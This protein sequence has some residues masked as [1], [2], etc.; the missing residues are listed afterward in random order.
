MQRPI[1]EVGK[2]CFGRRSGSMVE[3]NTDNNDDDLAYSPLTIR[4]MVITYRK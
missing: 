3:A 1:E 2:A 4:C